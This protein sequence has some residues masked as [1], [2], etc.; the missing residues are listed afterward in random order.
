MLQYC[1]CFIFWFFGGTWDLSSLT[2]D[3]TCSPCTGRW[4]VNR[5]T[6][7]DIPH[8]NLT[9]RSWDWDRL[10]PV[11]YWKEARL[12]LVLGISSLKSKH[13][14]CLQLSLFFVF[15][16]CTM[17]SILG[18]GDLE[19]QLFGRGLSDLLF[20]DDSN[21]PSMYETVSDF[22]SLHEKAD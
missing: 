6:T 17:G 11:F 9:W 20:I 2:R 14:F 15:L 4:S 19:I 16:S 12:F 7:R 22:K 21:L 5:W 13:S 18:K 10:P 3:Q 1:F 8:Q